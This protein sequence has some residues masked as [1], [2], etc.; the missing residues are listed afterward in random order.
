MLKLF[1]FSA[2]IFCEA[3]YSA[4]SKEESFKDLTQIRQTLLEEIQLPAQL[5]KV[6]LRNLKSAHSNADLKYALRKIQEAESLASSTT[7]IEFPKRFWGQMQILKVEHNL[8]MNISNTHG[9]GLEAGSRGL[10]MSS[11]RA[12]AAFLSAGL[13]HAA[14]KW[15]A[16]PSLKKIKLRAQSIEAN[17]LPKHL[18]DRYGFQERSLSTT[19][20]VTIYVLEFDTSRNESAQH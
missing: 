13:I 20:P 11:S 16:D 5:R 10:G 6:L 9:E 19:P 12:F 7:L 17:W 18:M 14:R 15:L 1:L 8:L 4:A 2:L 3:P